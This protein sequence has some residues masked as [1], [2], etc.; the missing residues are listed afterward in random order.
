[1][2]NIENVY[3]FC[4]SLI[5]NNRMLY[6]V[7]RYPISLFIITAILYLSFFKPPSTGISTIPHLDKVAHFCMY[8][9]LS[10]MLWLEFIRNQKSW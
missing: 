2:A 10:G 3:Y 1:M 8:F 6:Y 9:G 4:I 7:R 5:G